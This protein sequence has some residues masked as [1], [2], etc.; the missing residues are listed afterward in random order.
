MNTILKI[1]AWIVGAA[2]AVVLLIG[3]ISLWGAIGL[4]RSSPSDI[5]DLVWAD[6]NIQTVTPKST[7]VLLKAEG[8]PTIFT[9]ASN[10]AD[11]PIG[12]LVK[13]GDQIS[14]RVKKEIAGN[15]QDVSMSYVYGLQLSNGMKVLE[16]A[17]PIPTP[18]AMH[19]SDFAKLIGVP[20]LFFIVVF[21]RR[22]WVRSKGERA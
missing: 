21:S 15:L 17:T 4:S 18:F 19:F 20:V 6:I 22:F 7:S 11:Q 16:D 12:S 9:V 8:Y 2:M 10:A 14:V 3:L 13:P 1:I 5:G